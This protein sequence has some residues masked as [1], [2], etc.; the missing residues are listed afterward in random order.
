MV[1]EKVDGMATR[2]PASR[3]EGAVRKSDALKPWQQMIAS[4]TGAVVTALTMTPL[5]VVKIRL[6]A[7]AKPMKS[8]QCFIYCNGLMDHVC[9]CLNGAQPG[10]LKPWYKAP[11]HFTGTLDAFVK[12]TRN[13]GIFKLWS[14]LSPTLVM[15][16]PATVLYYTSYDQLR[17]HLGFEQ[18]I[19]GQY[20]KPMV[21][22]GTARL[23]AC[24]V[25]APL[26]LI[27]TKM[28][29]R[30][31]TYREIVDCVQR[32]VGEDGIMSLWRGWSPMVW[33]DVPFSVVL[34]LSYELMKAKLCQD[35]GVKTPTF[36]MAFTAAAM[37]GTIAAV[38][39]QP[40]DVIKTHRQIELGELGEMRK[41]ASSSTVDI[42]K[43]LYADRGINGLYAGTL[44]RLAKITPACALMIGS[45][46]MG[47]AFFHGH[48][49]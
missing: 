43:K 44:P 8:G 18:G 1:D 7:Q 27:R 35:Y 4:G 20:W 40:F 38:L 2:T 42:A 36:T 9:T 30:P 34:W 26:E 21:A 46:E 5:D 16:V 39:T 25:I 33:R 41:S 24:S 10:T 48:G 11:S 49:R 6:Q 22:G 45:Y 28:Q 15:A 3:T 29:S 19:N 37:S 12:I 32:A 17:Y 13:E 47:K 14:G 31:L 23:F